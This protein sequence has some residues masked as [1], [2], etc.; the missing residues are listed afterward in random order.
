MVGHK[1][2]GHM[3]KTMDYTNTT[4]A[5]LGELGYVAGTQQAGTPRPRHTAE[6][7]NQHTEQKGTNSTTD[8][9]DTQVLATPGQGILPYAHRNETK[10]NGISKKNMDTTGP[11]H[12]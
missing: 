10:R 3:L 1:G 12:S 4:K 2:K 8:R 7:N 11:T 5:H 9:Q 6:I